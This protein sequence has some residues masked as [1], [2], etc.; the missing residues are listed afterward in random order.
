MKKQRARALRQ[1]SQLRH[2][3]GT[4]TDI[5][6]S[7]ATKIKRLIAL[8]L[9]SSSWCCERK[10]GDLDLILLVT[11]AL[12][13]HKTLLPLQI[14]F[15]RKLL[16]TLLQ[17]FATCC[18]ESQGIA[19]KSPT[20]WTVAS[21]SAS[22]AGKARVPSSRRAETIALPSASFR[23]AMVASRVTMASRSCFC[24]RASFSC[25]PEPTLFQITQAA[26]VGAIGCADQ[27]GQHVHF[28]K[29]R[30]GPSPRIPG[31]VLAPPNTRPGSLRAGPLQP[32]GCV[33][34]RSS[35]LY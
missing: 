21:R 34:R 5:Q 8:R 12:L 33:G 15:G 19:R 10:L 9:E 16:Q 1:H 25:R 13:R 27:V 18:L 24:W 4:A 11:L 7:N 6:D 22:S 31:D 30:G 35:A 26:N 14:K 29:K 20:T 2:V 28:A 3:M 23:L 32:R 17:F